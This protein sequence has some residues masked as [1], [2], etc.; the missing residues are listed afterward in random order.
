MVLASIV[1]LTIF[2]H[3]QS[4][5][6]FPFEFPNDLVLLLAGAAGAFLLSYL[7]TFGVIAGSRKLGLFDRPE[8]GRTDKKKI[9]R[10]GGVGIFLAFVVAS[11]LF[12][13]HKAYQVA[14]PL[15]PE[16][17]PETT[18]YWLFLVGA[19]L[20][21]LVHAYDDLKPL[22]PLVKLVAQTLAVII[23]L[24]PFGNR[25]NGVLLFGFSNP[26]SAGVYQ[27]GLP[28]YRE[29]VITLF[30]HTPDITLAA[31]PAVLFTWFWMVGMMNTVNLID[32]VD[33][34]AT[35]VV[36]IT[37]LCITITSWILH[38]YT[39][40]IL[41][42][43]FTGAVLGF[44]PHN[45]NPAKIIMGDSGAHFLGLGLAVLSIIGG[46]KVGAALM[47][48][49]I[50][51]LD[52]AV[53]AINRIRRGQSPLHYDTTHLHHRLRATGLNARQICYVFY[54]LTAIFGILSLNL[55][56]IYKLIGIGLVVVAMIALITWIDY[57]QRRR[58]APIHLGDSGSGP[59]LDGGASQSGAPK[60]DTKNGDGVAQMIAT[61]PLP[62]STDVHSN[63]QLP[64]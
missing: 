39:I 45:W 40:A 48:L 10:L 6:F 42:A 18:I 33:G 35:G 20:I 31:I 17:N 8:P 16:Q 55:L 64:R 26:F 14:G 32:G 5:L 60:A 9:S 62:D 63:A 49:G 37:A 21:V 15:T 3:T 58:G 13:V 12:Y 47:V 27:P 56:R 51:I 25:F 22:K 4:L 2:M 36:A 28:W 29:P 7:F 54:S 53:V 1:P 24:G 19:V 57:R 11:L 52:L 38:Q 59:G 46:A 34:L 30:I 44:L 43:I 23:V 61:P 41:A 50:P